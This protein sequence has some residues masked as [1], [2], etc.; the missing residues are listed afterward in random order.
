M[1]DLAKTITILASTAFLAACGG[2]GTE[3]PSTGSGF[4]SSGGGASGVTGNLGGGTGGSSGGGVGSGS[5]SGGGGTYP[6][7]ASLTGDQVFN[8]S[9]GEIVLK[10][11][12]QRDRI[13][14]RGFGETVEYYAATNTY[15]LD[16]IGVEHANFTP[17]PA[18][19]F[20]RITVSDAG[21]ELAYSRLSRWDHGDTAGRVGFV[22]HGLT[23][24][25][26]DTPSG[27]IS[28]RQVGFQGAAFRQESGQEVQYD[29]A[30]S[31]IDLRYDFSNFSLDMLMTLIGTPLKGGA[32]QTLGL[33]TEKDNTV[34]GGK[35]DIDG[36][37]VK[38]GTDTVMGAFSL[39]FYGPGATEYGLAF[40]M[41]ASSEL[42]A[43]G[44]A[45]GRKQ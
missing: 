8:A 26:E 30:N 10:N 15:N 11:T 16:G 41:N 35:N 3:R 14:Y 31:K 6:T 37:V 18:A 25:D 36:F 23:T 5:G 21:G 32:D 4:T 40:G 20:R 22:T 2:A 44:A 29:L 24:R 1:P 28:Y 19:A 43:A 34:V 42:K 9:T 7:I 17:D 39:R 27:S 12:A 38:S 45:A 33:F 13:D